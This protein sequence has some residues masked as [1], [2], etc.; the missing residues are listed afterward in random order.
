M[1]AQLELDVDLEILRLLSTSGPKDSRRHAAV[2][3]A[4]LEDPAVEPPYAAYFW[5]REQPFGT[6]VMRRLLLGAAS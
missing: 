2:C 1:S 3:V 5:L 6:T 4:A